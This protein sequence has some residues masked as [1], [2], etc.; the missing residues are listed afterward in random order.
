V[1]LE[2]QALNIGSVNEDFAVESIA[3]DIFQLGNASYRILRVEPGGCGSRMPAS[4]RPFRSGSAKRRGA[5][6]SCRRGPAAGAIDQQLAGWRRHGRG[7]D[8]LQATFEL[9]EAAPGSCSTTWP[10]PAK[11]G[12]LPSQDTLVM[13]RFSMS[14][15]GPN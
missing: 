2:P 7:T 9:G 13:E 12:A 5:V 10:A 14:P 4:H 11:C 8:W 15:A 6:T 3:G 1:L